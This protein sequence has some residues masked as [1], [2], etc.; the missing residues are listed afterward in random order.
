MNQLEAALNTA[1]TYVKALSSGTL[2]YVSGSTPL[3]A[4]VYKSFIRDYSREM[5]NTGYQQTYDNLYVLVKPSDVASWGLKPM[6][7]EVTL[8]GVAYMTGRTI[9]TTL[10]YTTIFLRTKD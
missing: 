3:T 10:G 5:D 6:T 2:N 1:L 4:S 7:S 8:D 9:N